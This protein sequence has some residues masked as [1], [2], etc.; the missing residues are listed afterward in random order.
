MRPVDNWLIDVDIAIANLE[1]VSALRRG[2]DPRFVVNRRTLP[3]EIGEW[4]QCPFVAALT[5]RENNDL[6]NFCH[7]ATPY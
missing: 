1:V 3:S 5:R 7:A 6:L 2:T 4:D